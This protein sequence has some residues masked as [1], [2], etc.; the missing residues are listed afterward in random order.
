MGHT[1]AETFPERIDEEVERHI[2]RER[3]WNSIKDKSLSTFSVN[4]LDMILKLLDVQREHGSDAS[5]YEY[6]LD[7]ME[8]RF[9]IK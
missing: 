7:E 4:D 9:Q 1:Y 3:I 5:I 8:E 6:E 2:R